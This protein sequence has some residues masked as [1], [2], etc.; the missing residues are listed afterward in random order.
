VWSNVF[1]TL[2]DFYGYY[3]ICSK[4]LEALVKVPL[5]V[6]Y[7]YTIMSIITF[8]CYGFDKWKAKNKTWR[9]PE[10]TLHTLEF[11]GGW[12][13]AILGQLFFRHKTSKVSYQLLF[14]II[15]IVH[16]FILLSVFSEKI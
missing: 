7:C 4:L 2:R 5:W 11:I 3:R 16:V 14:W 15:V 9:I 13:G 1:G 12:P 8:L 6:F 10:K